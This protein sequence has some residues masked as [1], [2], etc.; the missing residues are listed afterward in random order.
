MLHWKK[1]RKNLKLSNILLKRQIRNVLH[2]DL[3]LRL[4]K[5]K[6]IVYYLYM[7][8]IIHSFLS[9]CN[10]KETRGYLRSNTWRRSSLSFYIA[11]AVHWFT[12]MIIGFLF[13]STRT[14]PRCMFDIWS[15]W[16]TGQKV[17]LV[18]EHTALPQQRWGWMTTH[19]CIPFHRGFVGQQR[20]FGICIVNEGEIQMALHESWT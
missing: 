20:L 16:N 10:K 18:V 15:D 12:Q 5:M 19:A 1:T 2:T 4:L 11:V 8:T 17:R 9:C 6:T 13:F 7:K 14:K 3:L